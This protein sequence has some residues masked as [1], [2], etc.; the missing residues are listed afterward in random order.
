MVV[1][2][3]HFKQDIPRVLNNQSPGASEETLGEY[4]VERIQD[5]SCSQQCYSLSHYMNRLRNKFAGESN[6]REFLSISDHSYN[7]SHSRSHK[8]GNFIQ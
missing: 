5:V 6:Q 2:V 8:K 3:T 4:S 1:V 7:H